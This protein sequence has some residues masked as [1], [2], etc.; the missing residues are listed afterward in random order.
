MKRLLFV[1]LALMSVGLM[2]GGVYAMSQSITGRNEAKD[3]LAAEKI[4]TTE[5][6]EIPNTPVTD[7]TTAHAMADVIQKHALEATGGLS[8]AELGRYMSADNPDDPAGTSDETAALLDEAGNPVPNP[9]RTVALQ[10]VTLRSALLSSALAFH[11]AELG[12]GV[13]LFLIAAGLLGLGLLW[14]IRL[15]ASSATSP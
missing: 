9:L 13:G 2:A 5:D 11:L 15:N 4:V 10:A 8:Y 14:L 6:A 7:H 12:L 3:K 1:G